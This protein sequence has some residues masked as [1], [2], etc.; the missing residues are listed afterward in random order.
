[1]FQLQQFAPVEAQANVALQAAP[2]LCVQ[3]DAKPSGRVFSMGRIAFRP[4]GVAVICLLVK[5]AN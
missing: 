5:G 3:K 1:M 4:S 2:L